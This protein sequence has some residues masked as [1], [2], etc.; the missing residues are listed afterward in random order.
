M[1]RL[2]MWCGEWQLETLRGARVSEYIVCGGGRSC[3]STTGSSISLKRWIFGKLRLK[4]THRRRSVGDTRG[5]GGC[6]TGFVQNHLTD[7]EVLVRVL[8][9]ED[10]SNWS[11]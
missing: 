8:E 10:D 7:L 6:R 5:C 2:L 4:E 11:L 1:A 9:K 3:G